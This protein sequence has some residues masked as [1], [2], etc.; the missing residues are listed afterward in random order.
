MNIRFKKINNRYA[1]DIV[2]NSRV[3]YSSDVHHFLTPYVQPSYKYAWEAC[4][5]SNKLLFKRPHHLFANRD[6]MTDP[7]IVDISA[8]QMLINHYMKIYSG[9]KEQAQGMENDPRERD[10]TYKS[11]KIV[12]G[13]VNKILETLTDDISKKNFHILLAKIERLLK[14]YF[15]QEEIKQEEKQE[16]EMQ[17]I[18]SDHSKIKKFGEAINL[19][20]KKDV[21]DDYAQKI[22]QVVQNIHP[23]AYYAISIDRIKIMNESNNCILEASINDNLNL[24]NII[25]CGD[26]RK[27][28]PYHS[29]HFYQRYW[30]PIVEAIGHVV[31]G[32]HNILIV[33]DATTLPDVPKDIGDATID[34]WNI[35]SKKEQPLKIVFNKG[36]WNINL[37]QIKTSSAQVSQYEEQDYMNSIVKCIDKN[38]ESIF[39]RTGAVIEVVPH[40]DIIEI[41]VDFGRGI[42]II[43]LTEDQIQIVSV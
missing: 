12:E 33:P 35:G 23:D 31:I 43:R 7:V 18:A 14:K 20:I 30:K 42:G 11:I 41:D 21:I 13:E 38:L 16:G 28:C 26:L 32:T 39:N 10:Y 34:G 22:C 9:L 15:R 29:A 5:D 6:D 17:E 4:R 36:I 24:I 40:T 37:A 8:E 3:I 2:D 1:F 25:S 27:T 19:N